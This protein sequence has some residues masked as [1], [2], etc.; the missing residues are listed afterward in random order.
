MKKIEVEVFWPQHNPA[1]RFNRSPIF[2]TGL[3]ES[4]PRG[5]SIH[6]IMFEVPNPRS[7]H[8]PPT[9]RGQSTLP[10]S[11]ARATESLRLK[12]YLRR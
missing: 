9:E 10:P 4:S 1:S 8:P 11:E 12:K 3:G 6:T 5:D 2:R 7:S